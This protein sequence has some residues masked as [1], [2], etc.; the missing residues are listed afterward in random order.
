[1][2]TWP[3]KQ[4]LTEHGDRWRRRGQRAGAPN[5]KVTIQNLTPNAESDHDVLRSKEGISQTWAEALPV[6][7]SS[8]VPPICSWQ[9]TKSHDHQ[10]LK[11]LFF[12]TLI[13]PA[14]CRTAMPVSLHPAVCVIFRQYLQNTEG[15][16][17][18]SYE[19][20]VLHSSFLY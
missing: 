17:I 6:L 7:T 11:C 5:N 2:A 4:R 16:L 8:V 1:M 14:Q 13:T 12:Q 9:K 19:S 15:T 10:T 18:L 20:D 3:R